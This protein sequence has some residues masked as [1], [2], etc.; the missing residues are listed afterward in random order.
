MVKFVIMFRKP[1]NQKRF[2]DN[3]NNFL[4][5]IE[6]MPSITRRQVNTVLGSP[7]GDSPFY[8]VL[9]I[10][11]ESEVALQESLMSPAGQ[12]AGG[13]LSK[14]GA[15]HIEI[16]YAEVYE[17]AGGQTPQPE[18]EPESKSESEPEPESESKLKPESK[19]EPEPESEAT[20]TETDDDDASA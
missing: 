16:F 6:R 7:V 9:E 12:E 19:L 2:E 14:F 20:A 11:F 5:L 4:A 13:E 18:P 8:R 3:Y 17:E 10:Y 15:R 1:L